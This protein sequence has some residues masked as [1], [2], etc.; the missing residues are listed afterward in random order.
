MLGRYYVFTYYSADRQIARY[1]EQTRTLYTYLQIG[2]TAFLLR[3]GLLFASLIAP[4]LIKLFTDR[5]RLVWLA[6]IGLV[7]LAALVIKTIGGKQ[8]PK[9]I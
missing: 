1:K 4:L 9:N 3:Y 8:K 7:G 2:D 5:P 6:G